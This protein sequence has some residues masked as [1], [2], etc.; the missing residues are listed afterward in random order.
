LL[1]HYADEYAE[2]PGG[3]IEGV[4]Y[5]AGSREVPG[6][7]NVLRA[8]LIAESGPGRGQQGSRD[9]HVLLETNIDDMSPELLGH[10]AEALRGA[11][12]LDV[13]LTGATMK[14]GRAGHVLSVLA[15]SEDGQRLADLVFAE[16]S[17]FGV[18]VLEVGRLYAD[19]RRG[20]IVVEGHE[21]GVR[22]G[23]VAGRLVTVSPEYEDVLRLALATDRPVKDAY[24]LAQA[25]ARGRW[26]DP[27][28]SPP[29]AANEIDSASYSRLES[30]VS[31]GTP[32]RPCPLGRRND[33]G[34]QRRTR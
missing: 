17:S 13:W 31:A 12:A 23:H 28:E 5:G 34:Y 2:M 3:L 33:E 32:S 4:G 7:P 16:T 9:D 29:S 15:R 25:T 18:R 22:L 8:T 6:R 11:G 30:A 19:E 24:G 27:G 20:K 10:A 21:I 26:A 1:R 14:K